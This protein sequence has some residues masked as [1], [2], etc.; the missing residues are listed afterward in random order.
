MEERAYFKEYKGKVIYCVNYSDLKNEKK[1]LGIIEQTSIFRKENI[2]NKEKGSQLML[3]NIQD[4]FVLG[5][6]FKELKT[7]GAK[8]APFLK[9]QAI[10]GISGGKR[11]F[12][13]LY[14]FFIRREMKAFVTIEEAL[15]WLIKEG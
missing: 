3:V 15:E 10:V 13:N 14:N 4:S 6:V 5:D 11:T 8:T 1:F 2:E 9:K 7:V 12:L